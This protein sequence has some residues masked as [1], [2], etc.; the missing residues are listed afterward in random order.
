MLFEVST[1]RQI[2]ID[3]TDYLS[4]NRLTGIQQVIGHLADSRDLVRFLVFDQ[5]CGCYREIPDLPEFNSQ[6]TPRRNLTSWRFRAVQQLYFLK[7]RRFI[8]SHCPSLEEKIVSTARSFFSRHVS[9]LRIDLPEPL[10]QLD[11]IESPGFVWLLDVPRSESHLRFLHRLLSEGTTR[12]GVYL[13]D[14]IPLDL[15][16]LTGEKPSAPGLAAFNRYMELVGRASAVLY[17]S[18]FTRQRHRKY[19]AR[20]QI[21]PPGYSAVVYPP[22]VSVCE[23]LGYQSEAVSPVSS[24]LRLSAEIPWVLSVAPLIKR[25]N[26]KVVLE[27][28]EKLIVEGKRIGLIVVAPVL[29]DVDE[30]TLRLAMRL[31]RRYPQFIRVVNPLSQADYENLLRTVS[32]VVVPSKLEGFGIPVLEASSAGKPVLVSSAGALVEVASLVGGQ[33][34]SESSASAWAKSILSALLAKPVQ[35]PRRPV[36]SAQQFI[37]EMI[38]AQTD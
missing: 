24:E 16:E 15:E 20:A 32:L 14:L 13:Y 10:E 30:E 33:I 3:V 5:N 4:L 18:N 17:L 26:V 27:A 34:V 25:K 31:N 29:G 23:N 35:S 7:F 38:R 2:H 8:Q 11:A 6:T 28:V 9:Q 12:L 21:S 36:T 22:L 1:V 37:S 19:L